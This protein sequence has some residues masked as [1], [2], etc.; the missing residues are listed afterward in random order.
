[1]PGH[2]GIEAN[3][4]TDKLTRKEAKIPFFEP[5]SLC[6]LLKS[7]IKVKFWSWKLNKVMQKLLNIRGF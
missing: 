7:R 2:N 6:G 3:E 1:M 5:K 4:Q